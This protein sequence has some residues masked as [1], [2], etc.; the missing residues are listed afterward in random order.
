MLF[1]E[2]LLTLPELRDESIEIILSSGETMRIDNIDGKRGSLR[3]L[4]A[5]L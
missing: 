1:R 4:Q 5:F 3:L 2:Y